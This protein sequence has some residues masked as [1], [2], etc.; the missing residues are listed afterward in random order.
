MNPFFKGLEDSSAFSFYF[1]DSGKAIPVKE[2][3]YIIYEGDIFPMVIFGDELRALNDY[4]Y[5]IVTAA[6]EEQANIKERLDYYIKEERNPSAEYTEF[7]PY[8]MQISLKEQQNQWN[9]I[10]D[11]TAGYLVIF[12]ADD[13]GVLGVRRLRITQKITEITRFG[14][15][16]PLYTDAIIRKLLKYI[17]GCIIFLEWM[18]RHSGKNTGKYLT[19]WIN[20]ER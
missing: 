9:W 20:A 5:K 18:K 2:T 19:F 1:D 13:R 4:C 16:R 7:T 10:A 8:E 3:D 17:S 11:V 6:E 14:A 12:K 15:Y